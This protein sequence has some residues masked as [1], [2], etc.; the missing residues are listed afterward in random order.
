MNERTPLPAKPADALWTD[1]Q[2][3]AI[4]SGG[5]DILVAAAEKLALSD[6]SNSN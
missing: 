6:V 1:D 4:V 3:K 2:W 5:S